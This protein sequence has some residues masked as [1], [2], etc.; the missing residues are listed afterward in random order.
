MATLKEVLNKAAPG[1]LAD[2]L[3]KLRIGDIFRSLRT[4][5]FA[6]VPT[7]APTD[8]IA[9]VQTLQLP[10]DGKALRVIRAFVRAGTTTGNLVPDAP[11]MAAATAT[12]HV[13]V[14]ESGDITF[15]AA[16]APTSVD[17]YY[18]TMKGELYTATLP[19][20]SGTGVCALPAA[21]VA[22]G[23]QTILAA[24]AVT[25]TTTGVAAVIAPGAVPGTTHQVNLDLTKKQ[26]QFRIADVV[27]SCTISLLLVPATDVA[28][29]LQGDA[30]GYL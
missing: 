4:Q 30:G 23:I 27:T 19:V 24:N 14:S 16:D 9:A 21:V 11:P 28:A 2:I 6:Q 7:A 13:N 15:A 10:T 22:Q 25:G 5:L 1:V 26:V 20:V 8:M 17:V 12:G 3:K 18:E 29:L